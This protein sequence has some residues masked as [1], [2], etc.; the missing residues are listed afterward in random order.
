MPRHRRARGAAFDSAEGA[1]R[2]VRQ[3]HVLQ[4]REVADQGHL[5]ERGL[6]PQSLGVAR[7][8]EANGTPE[9]AEAAGT[10]RSQ[11]RQQL[12]DG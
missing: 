1:G 3:H 8:G 9:K 10:G 5:L 4:H 7:R 12:D 6:H 11:S 2:R